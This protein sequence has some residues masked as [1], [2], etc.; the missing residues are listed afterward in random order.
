M[1]AEEGRSLDNGDYVI[2]RLKSINDGNV[3]VLDKEQVASITQ[4]IEASYGMMD[5]D[6]YVSDLM[7]HAQV[8]KH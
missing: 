1:N 7:S 3:D 6:L 5:Y 8:V 4:Q 2:V